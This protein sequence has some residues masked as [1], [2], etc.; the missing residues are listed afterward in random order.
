LIISSAILEKKLKKLPLFFWAKKKSIMHNQKEGQFFHQFSSNNFDPLNSIQYLCEDIHSVASSLEATGIGE[1]LTFKALQSKALQLVELIQYLDQF[2]P[3][4]LNYSIEDSFR[5]NHVPTVETGFKRQPQS[6]TVP[7]SSHSIGA[8]IPVQRTLSDDLGSQVIITTNIFPIQNNFES[9]PI[10]SSSFLQFSHNNNQD[11]S[12]LAAPSHLLQESP[13]S[14]E[15]LS[16][17]SFDPTSSSCTAPTP[18]PPPLSSASF[19]LKITKTKNGTINSGVLKL[20]RKPKIPKPKTELSKLEHRLKRRSQRERRIERK[21]KENPNL[22]CCWCHKTKT[23]EWRKGPD[24]A[25]TLCNA[26]GIRYSKQS[27]QE[28]KK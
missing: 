21:Q 7:L 3:Q 12:A 13:Y 20:G 16:S 22:E 2:R 8:Q 23:P 14:Q 25:N 4:P 24:G 19:S 9:N 1:N 11:I 15:V 28:K 10:P 5:S 26:C 17:K 18:T 6:Q 27:K